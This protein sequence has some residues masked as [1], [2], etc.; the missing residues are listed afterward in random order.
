[1]TTIHAD[2]PQ[3][4]I[5]QLVMLVLESGTALGRAD[6]HHF[7]RQSIDLIVQLSRVGGRRTVTSVQ[8][9]PDG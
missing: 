8:I 3:G 4:A 2:S 7:A 5:E 9:M 6:I 1:M